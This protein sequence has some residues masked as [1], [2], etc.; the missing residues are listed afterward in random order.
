MGILAGSLHREANDWMGIK[1]QIPSHFWR[2]PVEALRRGLHCCCC[3]W[4]FCIC[5]LIGEASVS[6]SVSPASFTNT[7]FVEKSCWKWDDEATVFTL[8]PFKERKERFLGKLFI[9]KKVSSHLVLLHCATVMLFWSA[10]RWAVPGPSAGWIWFVDPIQPCGNGP[11]GL[12]QPHTAWKFGGRGE[13]AVLIA[14]APLP[15]NF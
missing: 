4:L 5:G 12:M 6:K 13:A 11:P 3:H 1:T 9:K 8:W 10:A 7:N 15:P 2:V 14:T